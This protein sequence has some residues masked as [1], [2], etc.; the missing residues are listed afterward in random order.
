[1]SR[2]AFSLQPA[3]LRARSAFENR[4]WFAERHG[5]VERLILELLFGHILFFERLSPLLADSR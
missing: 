4:P 2:R 5:F 1:M 3:I